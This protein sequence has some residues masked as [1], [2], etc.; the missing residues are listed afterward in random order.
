M[1]NTCGRGT[2]QKR[3][4]TVEQPGVCHARRFS[5]QSRYPASEA[6]TVACPPDRG[7]LSFKKRDP[8]DCSQSGGGCRLLALRATVL[9]GFRSLP[10]VALRANSIR[11]YHRQLVR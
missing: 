8:D 7:Q 9:A 4:M 10:T 5:Q 11:V 3:R 6:T 1:L 2:Y